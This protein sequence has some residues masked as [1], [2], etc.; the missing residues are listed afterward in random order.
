MLR[1]LLV[2][3]LAIAGCELP[4]ANG[5]GPF[6]DNG[7]ESSDPG[8]PV[9][10]ETEPD[11]EPEPEELLSYAADIEPIF[12]DERW[13]DWAGTESSCVSCHDNTYTSLHFTDG[14][15]VLVAPGTGTLDD[16]PWVTPG[17]R[18]ASYLYLKITDEHEAAGGFGDVMPP[19]EDDAMTDEEIELVGLWID[20]GASP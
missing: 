18:W 11:P 9:S 1:P 7:P 13:S 10:P 2:L 16:V 19:G 5:D 14:Y 15:D 17:D 12:E 8:E 20:Q 4:E 6:S 3:A